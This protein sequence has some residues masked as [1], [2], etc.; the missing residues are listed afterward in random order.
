[1][2][3]KSVWRYF[4]DDLNETTFDIFINWKLI[5][6]KQRMQTRKKVFITKIKIS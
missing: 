3:K 1:M 4:S 2:L 5:K 6:S